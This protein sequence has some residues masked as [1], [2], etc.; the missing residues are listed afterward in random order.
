MESLQESGVERMADLCFI[1][2]S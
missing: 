2:R 1:M